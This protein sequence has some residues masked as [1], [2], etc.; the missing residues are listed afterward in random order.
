MKKEQEEFIKNE[1][2]N[3]QRDKLIKGNK[4][5]QLDEQVMQQLAEVSIENKKL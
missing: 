1:E 5:G 2:A 4:G 3:L